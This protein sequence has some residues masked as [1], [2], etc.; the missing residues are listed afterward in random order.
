MKIKLT[1]EQIQQCTDKLA[2]L[3][4]RYD[5]TDSEYRLDYIMEKI[6]NLKEVILSGEAEIN[7]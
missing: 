1:E 7:I 3:K 6:R 5:T 4:K 2:E